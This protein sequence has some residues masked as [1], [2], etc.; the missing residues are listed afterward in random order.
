MIKNILKSVCAVLS[1][2]GFL[3]VVVNAFLT[4]P[5]E[6]AY[7][8]VLSMGVGYPPSAVLLKPNGISEKHLDI[9]LPKSPDAP[10]AIGIYDSIFEQNETLPPQDQPSEPPVLQPFIPE[11]ALPVIEIDMSEMQSADN[12]IYRNESKYS[13]DINSLAASD[14]PLKYSQSASTGTDFQ[15]LVLIIHTHGTECYLPEGAAYYT[16]DTPTRSYDTE[17]NVIAVGKTL[18]DT[19]N[20]NGI[21]TLH[22]ETM[23][24]KESYS[25]SYDL[26]ELQEDDKSCR[27]FEIRQTL[28]PIRDRR[29]ASRVARLGF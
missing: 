28:Q 18:A 2:L 25:K 17:Q 21:D 24:D 10:I 27:L 6:N 5:V 11:N 8:T 13:P 4:Y 16:P 26:S 7:K 12:L 22:C 20:Q 19:L 23:F 29:S 15:P 1:I 9:D 3:L 14:Y